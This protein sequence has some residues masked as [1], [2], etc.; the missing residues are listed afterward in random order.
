M[1]TKRHAIRA[2]AAACAML[3]GLAGAAAVAGPAAPAAGQEQP[4]LPCGVEVDR[5]VSP[6]QIHTDETVH[7]KLTATGG[8][9][10]DCGGT[11][12]A[13]D[14]FF[15]VDN[16]ET[17]FNPQFG[18]IDPTR[19]ALIDF[20]NQMDF[21]TS[22]AGL[23][24]FAL[25]E[26]V[27]VNL[28]SDRE[29]LL[30]S[31]HTMRKEQE[32][33][34]RG[35]SAALRTATQKLDNDGTP[36]NQKMIIT[37][38]AGST[39]DTNAFV[40]L[41]TALNAARLAGVN[42]TMLMWFEDRVG[43]TRYGGIYRDLVLAAS[44]C[45]TTDT[46]CPNWNPGGRRWA[47]P[48]AKKD[49]AIYPWDD[50]IQAT[51]TMLIGR[52]LRPI[53]ITGIEFQELIHSGADFLR[54]SASPPPNAGTLRDVRWQAANIPAGGITIDYDARMVFSDQTY[55]VTDWTAV[56]VTTSDGKTVQ[57]LLPNP[58]VTVLGA[59]TP[60]PTE[61][62]PT[63]TRTPTATA[64][65]T[66]ATPGTPTPVTPTPDTPTATASP[67]TPAADTPS[68]TA[69][70]GSRVFVPVVLKDERWR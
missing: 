49:E 65:A 36:G 46:Q 54:A 7:V 31:I 16:T 20:V 33:D 5:T 60:T 45:E 28:S 15:V 70:P 8:D 24:T 42:F 23:I 11:S 50:S 66:P 56:S 38:I 63:A 58:D 6:L 55:P 37:I 69:E 44:P 30:Q 59:V 26:S 29:R 62:V 13:A 32:N 2:R 3:L 1:P 17:M 67:A 19:D 14:V 57:R 10:G 9:S 22:K 53:S 21:R 48:I 39:A 40:N 52:L 4:A 68:P 41:P 18:L 27:K 35:L 47:W 25:E 51:M 43:G 12:R 34:V 61:R 64:T